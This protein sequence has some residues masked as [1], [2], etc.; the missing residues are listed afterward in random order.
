MAASVSYDVGRGADD[1][2]AR[3]HKTLYVHVLRRRPECARQMRHYAV[4]RTLAA[5]PVLLYLRLAATASTASTANA[6]VDARR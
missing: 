5:A 4:Q 6:T 1:G 3:P 2:H